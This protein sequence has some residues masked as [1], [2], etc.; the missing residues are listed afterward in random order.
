MML[1]CASA[2]CSAAE[3]GPLT[4]LRAIE[5]LPS[6]DAEKG[7][8]VAFEATVTYYR[9]YESTL[10]VQDGDN[11]IYVQAPPDA[12]IVAGDRVLVRGTTQGSFRPSI[13]GK[14]IKLLRHGALPSPTP[15]TFDAMIRGQLD[16]LLVTVRATVRA[17]N[18]ERRSD[19]HQAGHPL[20]TSTRLHLLTEGGGIEAFIDSGEADANEKL[21]GAKVEITGVA[22][23]IF[24][25]KMQQTG[26]LLH[27]SSLDRVKVIQ[28]A[29]TDVHSLPISPMDRVLTGYRVRDLTQMVRVQG[30][31]TYYEPGTAVVLENGTR[32]LWVA[33]RTSETLTIGDRADATGFPDARSGFLTLTDGE[34]WDDKAPAGVTPKPATWNQLAASSDPFDLVSMEATVVR[35]AREIARD[36]FVLVS[37]GHIFSAIYHH[38]NALNNPA[39]PPMKEV[40]AGSR[41]RITGICI[42][43]DSNPFDN[44]VPFEILMR[45]EDDLANLSRPSPLN[46]RNLSEAISVLLLGILAVTSWGWTLRNKVRRQ[47]TALAQRIAAEAALERQNAQLEQRRSHILEEINGSR[48]L[49]EILEK[50]AE[51]VSIWLGGASCWCETGDGTR[52]G[53]FPP[54]G[55]HRRIVSEEIPARSGAPLGNLFA[56]LDPQTPPNRV[57]AEALSMGAR[58]STLAIE[59]RSL[60]SNLVHRSEFDLLTDLHNRFSLDKHFDGL[61]REARLTEGIFGLIYIDLDDFKSVNDQYGHQVGDLYLQE[62]ALRMKRQLRA[63]DMLARVG[64]DEFAVLVT[65][66]S[67]RA[68]AHEIAERLARSFDEPFAVEGGYVLHG[69]ASVGVALYPE[70]GSTKD[71]LLSA[72]D[73]A[74]YVAKNTKKFVN[75]ILA[76]QQQSDSALEDKP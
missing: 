64:G 53:N 27:V 60:Y 18:L 65:K 57:E 2:A 31:I 12:G 50:I 75:A 67:N 71:G 63:C 47:T 34:V 17:A 16:C 15:A 1:G 59:T 61:I 44:Q 30:T 23:G 41:V 32:S 9:G 54:E 25:G 66:I 51:L 37:D 20:V 43:E 72:A 42:L 8:A 36:E 29:P 21:L 70:D 26:V 22:G 14:E 5:A 46:V 56:A 28:A 73:A 10:F 33:T 7:V 52:I 62:V 48:P 45:T 6:A 74:M 4:T 49:A 68:G 11:A 69:S 19:A 58:L 76:R 39:V 3:P 38:P 13:N 55:D 35:Q 40:P 24:D